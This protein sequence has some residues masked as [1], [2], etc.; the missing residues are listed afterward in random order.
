MLSSLA[1]CS[2]LSKTCSLIKARLIKPDASIYDATPNSQQR[3]KSGIT[4]GDYFVVRN[5]VVGNVG[6]GTTSLNLSLI[7]I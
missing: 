4:T 6:G 5:T 7:H 1:R 2:A 3:S